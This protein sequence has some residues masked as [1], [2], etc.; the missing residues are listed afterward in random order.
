MPSNHHNVATP[1]A[2]VELHKQLSVT[3]TRPLSKQQR[4]R[5]QERVRCT[6]SAAIAS[7]WFHSECTFSNTSSK[8]PN[9]FLTFDLFLLVILLFQQDY[10][11]KENRANAAIVG[12]GGCSVSICC[13]NCPHFPHNNIIVIVDVGLP[14]LLLSVS[15]GHFFIAMLPFPSVRGIMTDALLSALQEDGKFERA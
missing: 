7:R 3:T 6:R 8:H 9:N 10:N 2:A 1:P 11:G 14:L 12:N 4:K 5:S 15:V 13:R